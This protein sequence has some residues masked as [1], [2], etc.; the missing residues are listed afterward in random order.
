[1][2]RPETSRR[3]TF[4]DLLEGRIRPRLNKADA[5]PEQNIVPIESVA[6]GDKQVLAAC[7]PKKH[8]QPLINLDVL[9]DFPSVESVIAST[10]IR[11]CASFTPIC[12][13]ILWMELPG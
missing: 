10:K 6:A 13:A 12:S 8:D 1:Q 9:A 7:E 3:Y 2:Q 4:D 11:A 5:H